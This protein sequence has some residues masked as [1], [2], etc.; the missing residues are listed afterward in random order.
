MILFQSVRF[1]C[2]DRLGFEAIPPKS[3]SNKT[4]DNNDDDDEENEALSDDYFKQQMLLCH[5]PIPSA[6]GR[7]SIDIVISRY[8]C[9]FF[10]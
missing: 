2:V 6:S 10:V 1:P 4:D 8:S 3:D 5:P 9:E 7:P